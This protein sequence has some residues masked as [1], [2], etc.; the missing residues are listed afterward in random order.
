MSRLND[1]H[2]GADSTGLDAALAAMAAVVGAANVLAD[3]ATRERYA[4]STAARPV[5]P[6]ALVRPANADEVAQLVKIA[7]G[8]GVAVYPISTGKNWGYGDAC[9]VGAGQVI[10]DL[11]RM[12]R[13]IHVDPELAYAV[14]EPGVTQRQLSDHLLQRGYPLWADCTGAGPD[15]SYIGNIME[16][17]FGHSPYG[18]RLQHVAGMQVVLAS[19]ELLETGFGHYRQARAAHLFPYGVGPFLDGLFTQSNMGIVTR[20]GIWLMPQA[21][22]VNHFLCSVPA[23]ADIA[24]VVDALR[25]LRLDGTLRSI[26][27]IGNDMRVFSGSGAFPRAAVPQGARLPEALRQ[28]MRAKGG[29]GAWT[30]SGALYGSHAQVAAARAA[31]RRALRGTKGRTRFVSERSLRAGAFAARL[32]GNTEAGKRLR[33]RVAL[34]ESLFAM[35]RGVPDGRFLSGAYWR[36]RGGVPVTFPVQA[37][38]AQDNCG[39][40]WVSP[41]LPLRG[42]DMLAVHE[43]AR[44]SFDKYGFDLFATFSMINE[45][46]LGGVLTVAYDKDDPDEAARAR[47]CHDEVFATMFEAGYIPYRV[48]NHAMGRLDPQGDSYWRTVGAIKAALDPA[49]ILAP[50]RYQ[51]DVAPGLI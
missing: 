37:N 40:L 32:L 19:G 11:S 34:G 25:P 24:D 51:P 31:V 12:N 8:A 26:L 15:T 6:L 38:P 7:A 13:I 47:A 39:L 49:G 46:A 20:L 3:G 42:A 43:L 16:R 28:Q 14:I 22:C 1:L 10:L 50:G 33:T 30:V 41:V 36:R 18:N 4:R 23:H 9:A 29:V 48:G 5:H 35:N 27:H 17:G 21:E 44:A 45:R 2:G